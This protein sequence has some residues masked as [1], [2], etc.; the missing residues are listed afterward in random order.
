[1][2]GQPY[3]YLENLLKSDCVD[4][5]QDDSSIS[6]VNT[7]TNQN[8]S[9]PFLSRRNSNFNLSQ[10]Y[11]VINPEKTENAFQDI[12][13]GHNGYKNINF[14]VVSEYNIISPFVKKKKKKN[15]SK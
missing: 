4:P 10:T 2:D 15:C 6:S 1:M 11:D 13:C 8:I 7:Y 3:T 12:F 5:D 14:D 9:L